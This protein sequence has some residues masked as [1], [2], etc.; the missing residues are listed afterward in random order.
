LRRGRA[1]AAIRRTGEAML[2]TGYRVHCHAWPYRCQNF[3]PNTRPGRFT[4]CCEE[5]AKAFDCSPAFLREYRACLAQERT[6]PLAP[7]RL[8]ARAAQMF[9][10]RGQWFRGWLGGPGPR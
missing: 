10:E 5:H 6:P 7:V 1:A 2:T 4:Y 8:V 3:I 9:V